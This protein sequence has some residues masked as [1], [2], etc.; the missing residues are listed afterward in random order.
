MVLFPYDDYKAWVG[1]YPVEVAQRQFEKI[2]RMWEPGLEKFRQALP[3][4][5][6]QK[7]GSARRDMGIAETCY[8][9]FRSVSNQIHFC[10]LRELWGSADPD[11]RQSIAR[12]MAR[13]ADDEIQLAKRQFAIARSDSTISFEASNHYYYRPLDLAEKVVSCADLIAR[14]KKLEPEH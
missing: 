2:A 5:P 13:I 10:R 12:E 14:L 6:E 11:G 8:S 7:R 4:I 1:S 3:M 9:H